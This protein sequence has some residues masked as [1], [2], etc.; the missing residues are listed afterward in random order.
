M[1][2]VGV[3]TEQISQQIMGENIENPDVSMEPSAKKMKIETPTKA[4]EFKLED[5][6]SGILC[7]AVCLDLPKV[8]VYQ[9]ICHCNQLMAA[10]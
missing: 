7:C 10:V 2:E 4:S 6:L 5:R 3:P 1:A 8:A 9:V